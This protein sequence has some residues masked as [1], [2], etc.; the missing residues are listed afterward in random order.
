M[1]P[2]SC[3][4]AR[5][6]YTEGLEKDEGETYL[7]GSVRAISCLDGTI[8][9]V[10]G[11][12]V[13]GNASSGRVGGDGRERLGLGSN[14]VSEHTGGKKGSTEPSCGEGRGC[15]SPCRRSWSAKL[16]RGSERLSEPAVV[17]QIAP[18]VVV[19]LETSAEGG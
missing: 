2:S 16:E 9:A 12:V 3:E 17:S 10:I 13:G 7:L 15:P 6:Q 11:K 5:R 14:I 18:G 1:K 4:A 19:S 8:V